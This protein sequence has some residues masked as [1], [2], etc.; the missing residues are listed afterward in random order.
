MEIIISIINRENSG[1]LLD[2]LLDFGS[3]YA[4]LTI[5]DTSG[6]SC[7][8]LCSNEHWLKIYMSSGLYKEC[9]L[10]KEALTQARNHTNGFLFLWDNYFPINE[11]SKYLNIL[12]EENNITHGV[13]FCLPQSDLTSVI[14][15]L[16]GK[17]HDINFSN[18][19]I[20]NKHEIYK[21][22]MSSAFYNAA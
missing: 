10:M 9:H 20:R 16:A 19:V 7:F 2:S 1:R 4:S 5:L 15:T 6:Q 8:S 13:A 14:I 22:V 17:K 21:A 3:T 11:Q 12:R 18:N